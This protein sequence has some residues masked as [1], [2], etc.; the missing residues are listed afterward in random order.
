MAHST[1]ALRRREL[2]STTLSLGTSLMMTSARRSY[3]VNSV[4]LLLTCLNIEYFPRQDY[5]Q[6][7]QLEGVQDLLPTLH[8][9]KLSID[10]HP[11]SSI[12]ASIGKI[13]HFGETLEIVRES[14][15]LFNINHDII[16]TYKN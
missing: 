5:R 9:E 11:D 1:S 12:Y 16:K 13:V 14:V 10:S 3:Q 7:L 15:T 4:V 8:Q 6:G 2:P